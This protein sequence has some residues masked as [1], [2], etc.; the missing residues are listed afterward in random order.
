MNLLVAVFYSSVPSH[1]SL[2]VFYT[3]KSI[4]PWCLQFGQNTMTHGSAYRSGK[5]PQLQKWN[6]TVLPN[7]SLPDSIAKGVFMLPPRCSPTWYGDDER[8][9]QCLSSPF[10][11]HHCSSPSSL[12]SSPGVDIKLVFVSCYDHHRP[13]WNLQFDWWLQGHYIRAAFDCCACG[14]LVPITCNIVC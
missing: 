6:F 14:T 3:T 5:L 2:T 7:S 13:T 9:P 11:V 10:S 12:Q 4:V 1:L 8:N